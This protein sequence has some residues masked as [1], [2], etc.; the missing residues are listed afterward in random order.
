MTDD[1]SNNGTDESQKPQTSDLPHPQETTA[2]SDTSLE[3]TQTATPEPTSGTVEL[4]PT[5]EATQLAEA[6]T[7]ETA[8]TDSL[9]EPATDW[10]QEWKQK[11]KQRF[12]T[13]R[14]SPWARQMAA[15]I[16]T[17]EPAQAVEWASGAVQKQGAELYGMA[18][19]IAICAWFLADLSALML[20][21]FVPD[22]PV[23]RL[24]HV[25]SSTKRPKIQDDYNIIFTRNLF[26]SQGIIPGEESPT[27][28]TPADLGGAPVRTSLPLN[29]IGTLILRNELRSIATIEDKSA[30]MVYPVRIDDEIPSKAKIIKI[31]SRKV[32][33]INTSTG[34]REFVDLPEDAVLPNSPRIQVGPPSA[35][36]GGAGIEKVTPN[37]FNVSRAEVDKT[38]ADLNNVLTQARAVP[39]FENGVPSGY[40]LFQIVP[41]SIYDKLGLQNGDVIA[42][43][44]GQVI[45]DPGKAFELL[46][47]LK[48]SNHLELQVKKDGKVQTNVYDIR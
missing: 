46:S 43:L 19:T 17:F 3:S 6:P 37:Q 10:K 7:S 14:Q 34:R 21:R 2:G 28:A 11:L 13:A 36:T 4:T 29:L 47:E 24:S 45:N 48:T 20:G 33:F 31:E 1:P 23:A 25:T 22:P 44:N 27:N 5:T 32:T 15:R 18:A 42:G 9:I 8:A 40:K 16:E 30:T 12:E 41:G 39:N 35:R 38:L 26:S